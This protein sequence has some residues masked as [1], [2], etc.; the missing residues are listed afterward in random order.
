MLWKTAIRVVIVALLLVAILWVGGYKVTQVSRQ[1][2][3]KTPDQV[4]NI[5]T[6]DLPSGNETLPENGDWGVTPDDGGLPTVSNNN[7]NNGNSGEGGT[8]STLPNNNNNSNN[9]E[10][11]QFVYSNQYKLVIDGHEYSIGQTTTVGLIRFLHNNCDSDATINSCEALPADEQTSET[12]ETNGET[13]ETTTETTQE[14]LSANGKYLT[15]EAEL[16]ELV[17]NIP[18]VEAL[19][20]NTTYARDSFEKPVKTYQLNGQTM[21][22]NDYAWHTS[23]FLISEDPFQYTCPYTGNVIAN[24]NNLDYDHIVPLKSVYLRGGADWTAEQMTAYAYDQDVG[25]DVYYSANRSKG[26]KGPAQWLPAVNVEDYC[27]SW[28]VICEKYNL[29]MTQAEIDICTAKIQEA[30]ANGQTVE[31]LGNQ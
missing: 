14:V 18:V 17:A 22:R 27:Y 30:L 19:P 6:P 7:N 25:I 20:T 3:L 21:N 16:E 24:E 10:N 12:S 23:R 5:K 13:D 9:S 8:D 4:F 1:I 31:F 26:D 2:E 28:L 29:T 15:D 11:A